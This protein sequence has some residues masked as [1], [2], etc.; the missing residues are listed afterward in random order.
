[1]SHDL[2]ELATRSRALKA[3]HGARAWKFG[4][5]GITGMAV[6][7]A[8]VALATGGAGFHYLIGVLLGTQASTIWNFSFT[9]RWVFADRWAQDGARRRLTNFWAV[10]NGAL[11]A[12]APLVAVLTSG[13]GIHYLAS[14]L[15]SLILVFVVRYIASEAWIWRPARALT[16]DAAS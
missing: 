2:A 7:T 6:N 16:A 5:V 13:L 4:L 9:D 8:V 3:R 10:N 14:N 15:I 12:R 1:M 11:V